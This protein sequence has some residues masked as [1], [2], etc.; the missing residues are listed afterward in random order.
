MKVAL[1]SSVVAVQVPR[2]WFW[3]IPWSPR[4]V[5]PIEEVTSPGA[6]MSDD[7]TAMWKSVSGWAALCNVLRNAG[8]WATSFCCIEYMDDELSIMNRMSTPPAPPG[9]STA[10]MLVAGPLG[11]LGV[12]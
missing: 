4:A 6:P 2:G 12:L 7:T 3:K 10:G 5:Q 11:G 8:I 1:G 9:T